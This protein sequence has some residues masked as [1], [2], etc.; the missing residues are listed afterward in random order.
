M[1][2]GVKR[3]IGFCTA[4]HR[5]EAS[6]ER[7]IHA[8]EAAREKI[9]PAA[10]VIDFVSPWFDHPLFIEAITERV[11]E[12]K[13]PTDA[14]WVFTAHSIPCS[15][16]KESTYVEELRKTASLVAQK[17]GKQ[18]WMLA[19]TSRSGNPADPWLE[20]DVCVW[21]REKAQKGIKNVL[22]IP[23]GFVADHVEVLFDLDVE[24]KEA[25][26]KAGIGFY[27]AK[28]VGDH[29]LFSQMMAAIIRNRAREKVAPEQTASETT[30]FQDGSR[31]S[32]VG[33]TAKT[34]FCFPSA[35]E[36]PCCRTPT[37]AGRPR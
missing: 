23:I 18:E 19:Y 22:A 12:V 17:L 36:P 37:T 20:P 5:S 6:L 4:A 3:S 32:K 33:R 27:R 11:K 15:L 34:C 13:A 8:V 9:G 30:L 14:A 28:T 7:Y 1:A 21:I 26:D 10:P 31:L 24:A 35:E 2:D 25:A 16:A 29:P